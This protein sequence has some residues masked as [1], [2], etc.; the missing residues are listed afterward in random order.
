MIERDWRPGNPVYDDLKEEESRAPKYA[1]G[2]RLYFSPSLERMPHGSHIPAGMVEV[3]KVVDHGENGYDPRPRFTYVVRQ[4]AGG[5]KQGAAESELHVWGLPDGGETK[6]QDLQ[7][8][9]E[10]AR[11]NMDAEESAGGQA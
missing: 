4:I 9:E 7:A 1:V 5:D 6:A 8:P 2:N 3:I 11:S 10:M